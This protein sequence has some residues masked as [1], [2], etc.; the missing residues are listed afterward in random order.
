MHMMKGILRTLGQSIIKLMGSSIHDERDGSFLGKGLFFTW[1]G[2]VYIIGYEGPALQLVFR[3]P[4]KIAYWKTSI[5]FTRAETPNFPR[6]VRP[7]SPT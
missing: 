4:E 5:G 3:A 6:E 2:R 1:H 7:S